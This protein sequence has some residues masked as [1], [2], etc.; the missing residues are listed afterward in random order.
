M[1]TLKKLRK[2]KEL[3]GEEKSKPLSVILI[4]G[5]ISE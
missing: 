4:E 5:V 1:R 2:E 3:H